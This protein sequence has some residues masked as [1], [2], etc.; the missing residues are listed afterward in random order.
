MDTKAA[1][2]RKQSGFACEECRRRKARCDRARPQCG[3]CTEAGKACIIIEKRLQRGPKKGLLDVMRSRTG[4]L[5]YGW[6]YP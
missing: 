1:G 4:E 2:F 6:M 5:H 3:L